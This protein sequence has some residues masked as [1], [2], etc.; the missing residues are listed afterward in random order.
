MQFETCSLTLDSLIPSQRPGDKIVSYRREKPFNFDL[1][2]FEITE[3]FVL[4]KPKPEANPVSRLPPALEPIP[5]LTAE[6][7]FNGLKPRGR[8]G[9]KLGSARDSAPDSF[10]DRRDGGGGGGGGYDRRDDRRDRDRRDDR[11]DSGG[12]DRRD[13]RRDRDRDRGGYDLRDDR[14]RYDRRDDRRDSGGYDRRDDRRDRDRSGYR[15]PYGDPYGGRGYA[16]AP[17]PQ[18]L[19]PPAGYGGRGD[20]H[21]QMQRPPYPSQPAYGDP[22][23]GRGYPPPGYQPQPPQQ[24]GSGGYYDDRREPGPPYKRPRTD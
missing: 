2:R 13:D 19:P 11:R 8:W 10:R 14:D 17:P 21:Y 7:K 22:R 23:G 4:A 9:D 16:G 20:S 12:Y 15:D 3:D 5:D 18:P 24:M 6:N 1:K